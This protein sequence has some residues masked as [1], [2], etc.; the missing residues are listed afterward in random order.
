MAGKKSAFSSGLVLLLLGAVV[1]VAYLMPSGKDPAFRPLASPSKP[2]C[3]P[4]RST[5][6]RIWR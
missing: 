5:I 3:A 6:C 4:S 1:A 2:F